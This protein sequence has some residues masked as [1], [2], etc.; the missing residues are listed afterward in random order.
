MIDGIDRDA[1]DRDDFPQNNGF[2]ENFAE[3]D[4]RSFQSDIR[5]AVDRFV[6]SKRIIVFARAVLQ[7][8]PPKGDALLSMPQACQSVQYTETYRRKLS[9]RLG[10]AAVMVA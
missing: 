5:Y 6:A 9:P 2:E 7:W 1:L 4:R 10:A 8:F 3:V